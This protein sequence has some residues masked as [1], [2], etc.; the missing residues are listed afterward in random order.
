MV[1]ALFQ[2]FLK[3]GGSWKPRVFGMQGKMFQAWKTF[4]C[5]TTLDVKYSRCCW[6][7][8]FCFGSWLNR[9]GWVWLGHRDGSENDWPRLRQSLIF[10]VINSGNATWENYQ[11]CGLGIKEIQSQGQHSNYFPCLLFAEENNYQA[12]M[13]RSRQGNGCHMFYKQSNAWC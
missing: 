10:S 1:K 7:T 11:F 8:A 6:G 9:W 13:T 5:L 12:L 4:G 2:R 3:L